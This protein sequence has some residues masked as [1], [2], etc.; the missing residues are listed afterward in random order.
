MAEAAES[1]ANAYLLAI[2][3]DVLLDARNISHVDSVYSRTSLKKGVVN[4][5]ELGLVFG[6]RNEA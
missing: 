4:D 3:L 5:V 2:L 1:N 6:I